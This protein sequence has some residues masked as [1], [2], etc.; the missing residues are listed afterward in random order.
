M[1]GRRILALLLLVGT[2]FVLTGCENIQNLLNGKDA[3]PAPAA[4]RS[5]EPS[6]DASAEGS[7][8]PSVEPSAEPSDEPSEEPSEPSE[9]PDGEQL[10]EGIP[11]PAERTLEVDWWD[12]HCRFTATYEEQTA[13][14]YCYSGDAL[15]YWIQLDF[16]ESG[17]PARKHS[18]T[19]D[20]SPMQD[21]RYEY[22]LKGNLARMTS[23]NGNR[24]LTQC[25]YTYDHSGNRLMESEFGSGGELLSRIA[26]TYDTEG[27][28]TAEVYYL[29]DGSVS[30]RYDYIYDGDGRLTE[31]V[32][33]AG[34]AV[35]FRT[36]YTYNPD[37]TPAE[38][39]RS[40]RDGSVTSR[41]EYQ[42]D[43]AGRPTK[44]LYDNTG[45]GYWVETDYDGNGNVSR[46]AEYDRNGASIDCVTKRTAFL[47]TKAQAAVCWDVFLE[48]YAFTKG[49]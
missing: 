3:S 41:T 25:T 37:G 26:Y 24:V 42:Y 7:E 11:L 32:Q 9:D 12:L 4:E 46:R 43:G 39:V 8:E 20:G 13:L 5:A 17:R 22:D 2:I 1:N 18:Y 19:A 35:S 6:A 44:T 45:E 29:E 23:Y 28:L 48:A 47:Y 38:E 21:I 10:P 27:V 34:D 33:S 16:D 40:R 49:S 36:V 15:D 30:H 14:F 31:K